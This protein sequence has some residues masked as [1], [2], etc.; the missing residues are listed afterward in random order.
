LAILILSIG[1]SRIYLGVHY[2]SDVL[3]GFSAGLAWLAVFITVSK[4]MHRKYAADE[5]II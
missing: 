2:P 5:Q 1:V 4:N 3:G